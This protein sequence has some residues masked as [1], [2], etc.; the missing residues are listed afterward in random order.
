MN[1]NIKL[2]YFVIPKS[3]LG[4][5]GEKDWSINQGFQLKLFKVG[6][7]DLKVTDIVI[8]AGEERCTGKMSKKVWNF[9]E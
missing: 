7:D 8:S 2:Y 5:C 3:K 6:D 9:H 4:S 1:N